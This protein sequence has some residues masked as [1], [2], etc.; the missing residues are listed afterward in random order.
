MRPDE[1][2]T[3][4]ITHHIQP[5]MRQDFD[6]WLLGVTADAAR[7]AGQQGVTVLRPEDA[8]DTEYVVIARFATFED[9][10][11]WE[12]S[13]ERAEWLSRLAPLV[14]EEPTYQTESGLEAWFRLPGHQ[15]VVPPGKKKMAVVILF[16]IYPLILI[17]APLLGAL[18]SGTPYLA[19]SVSLTPAFFTRTLVSAVILVVLMT[20]FAMPL[21]TKLLRGWLYPTR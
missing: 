1:S 18:L 6:E 12:D 2:V 19:V 20:W 9:L 3:W 8:A 4:V 5:D 7:F 14:T 17:V 11:R 10:R 15:V 16:A 21:L 13:P